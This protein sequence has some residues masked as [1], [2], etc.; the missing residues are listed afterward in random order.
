MKT[1]ISCYLTL[2]MVFMMQF[3]FAQNQTKT[4]TGKI[5][6]ENGL[7]VPGATVT[8]GNS[9]T[10]VAAD[11]NGNYT[12]EASQGDVLHFTAIGYKEKTVTVG[13]SNVINVTLSSGTLL[14][15]VVVTALG[16]E[17]VPDAVTSAQEIVSSDELTQASDPNIVSALAGKVTGLNI[18]LTNSGARNSYSI[19]LRGARS[20][21]GNN[22][23]LV[24]IDNVIS[25]ASVLASLPPEMIKSVNVI[26]G[27]QG[28]ALYG[29]DG[30]NGVIMVT[31]KKGSKNGLKVTV[32]STIDAE[33]VAYLPERQ[34]SYGQGW[35]NMRIQFENGAWGPKLDGS[36]T[37]YGLPMYDVDGDGVINLGDM[38]SVG[39]GSPTVGDNPAAFHG[40]YKA[41][42]DNIKNFFQTGLAYHNSVTLNAGNE[43]S[44]LLGNISNT[45]RNFIIDGDKNTN[46]NF[47]IKAGTKVGKLSIDGGITYIRSDLRETSTMFDDGSQQSL[48]WNLLQVAPDIPIT[49][50]KQYPDNAYAWNGYYMNPYW[51]MKHSR[52]RSTRDMF[53]LKGS[54]GYEFTDHI[55]VNY[56]ANMRRTFNKSESH[57]DAFN[58]IY[59]NQ[60]PSVA[61]DISSAYF[62]SDN[63]AM[64]YYGTL[65]LNF[66]YD[67]T[68]ALNLKLNLGHNYQEHT[69]RVSQNGGN[70]LSVAGVYNMSN[71][72]LPLPI[73]QLSNNHYRENKNS[74]FANLDLAFKDYL[75]VNLTARNE[76]ASVLPEDNNSYFYPSVG[77]SFVP[78][79][80][81]DNFGG[82]WLNHAKISANWTRVGNSSAISWYSVNRRALLGSGFPFNGVGSY[83]DNMSPADPDIKPEFVTSL[84]LNLDLSFFDN[85]V[86]FTGSIYKQDTKDMITSQ[87]TSS[88]S[89]LSSQ[90][91]NIGKMRTEGYELHIGVTPIK[92]PDFRWDL[93]VGYS[94]NESRVLKVSDDADEVNLGGYSDAAIVAHEGSLFPLIKVV[95]MAR[96]DQGRIIINPSNG[97]PLLD[98]QLSPAGIG[99]PKGIYDF[100]TKFTYK[101]FTLGVVA[102]LRVGGHFIAAVQDGM[103]FNGSL[104]ASGMNGHRDQGG[105]IMP[106]SVIPD[107]SNP[108]QY[109]PNTTVKTGGNTYSTVNSYFASVYSNA[110]ENWVVSSDAF[111]IREVSL[112]YDLPQ[113][114]LKG[115]GLRSVTL[116][117]HGR[118]V[119]TDLASDNL[120]YAD[121][122]TSNYGAVGGLAGLTQYPPTKSWGG[123]I[124][125]KL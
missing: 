93:G 37:M 85:R 5:T 101:G 74:V 107:V 125:I 2:I 51:L 52:Y 14:D 27:A 45:I 122:E 95:K 83:R 86:N 88:A 66:N 115:T 65:M 119:F 43:N 55:S 89:G 26:K 108:G 92:T 60:P 99:A 53:N 103:A 41:R 72:T 104:K 39:S 109:I 18:S 121:P 30:V 106:N 49:W 9:A 76:W 116:G 25:T 117:V 62:I 10:G 71:V 82:D 84:G 6:D 15:Q 47:M 61:S 96:D 63:D 23:A 112:T 110:K 12:I 17:K 77:V 7:S 80:A 105:F 48:Y 59:I 87:T 44:Y 31:T 40:A 123:S 64:D 38:I 124:T 24:V 56:T 11:A 113:E 69:Y 70:G 120:N 4:I 13:S 58:G 28:A 35:G 20:I 42:P 114:W 3:A 22:E 81:F 90:L 19:V 54:I 118:N 75:F 94:H 1:K 98:N 46:T 111:K 79:K 102:D 29:A 67:L 73:S 57:R 100:S 97:N 91:I 21:T 34:T 78:T 32:K 33:T 68:D 50:Y 8:V 36:Q 16:I